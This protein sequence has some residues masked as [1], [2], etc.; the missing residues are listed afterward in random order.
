VV[1]VKYVHVPID[2]IGSRNMSCRGTGLKVTTNRKS[3]EDP[4]GRRGT[5]QNKPNMEGQAMLNLKASIKKQ[6]QDAS[7][8]RGKEGS[9]IYLKCLHI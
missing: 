1:F 8:S 5:S 6:H 7:S 2:Y 3:R 4:D 9:S